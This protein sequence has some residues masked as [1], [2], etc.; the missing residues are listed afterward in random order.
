MRR[1]GGKQEIVVDV[2]IIAAT[3]KNLEEAIKK[4]RTPRGPLYRLNVFQLELPPLRQREG[5][6]PVWW[7]R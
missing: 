2:R 1:L 7:R 6:L 3:N 4:G 5:D